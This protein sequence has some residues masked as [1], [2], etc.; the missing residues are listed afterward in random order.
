MARVPDVVRKL[1]HAT[2]PFCSCPDAPRRRTCACVAPCLPARR[3][4]CTTGPHLKHVP[5]S[6]W[7][8]AQP[9]QWALHRDGPATW[10]SIHGPQ[11]HR[12]MPPVLPQL[13]GTPTG[14]FTTAC[15]QPSA[16]IICFTPVVPSV[17]C[18]AGLP[19]PSPTTSSILAGHV[20]WCM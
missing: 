4:H 6:T 2:H 7:Q 11:L 14:C 17:W 1:W 8:V 12:S 19:M 15:W 20:R 9:V 3:L 13:D 10:Q 5:L 16:R 18:L